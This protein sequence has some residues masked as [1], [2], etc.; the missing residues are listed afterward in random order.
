MEHVDELIAARA[1]RAL[2]PEEER[3]V[4]EHLAGCERCRVELR[5]MEAVASALA[6]SAPPAAPPPELRGRILGSIEPVVPS[7]SAAPGRSRFAWWPRFAAAAM[8]VLAV[9]VLALL[10]WN[11]SLRDRL[12]GRDVSAVARIDGVGSVV[13]YADGDV[14]L[15]AELPPAEE[16]HVYEAWVI[17]G[18]KPLPAG[19]FTDGSGEIDL[20]RPAEEGDVIAVTLEPGAGGDTPRGEVLGQTALEP[21]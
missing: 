1:L 4:D 7:P 13:R 15:F 5:Q 10:A 11:I 6:Y 14:K 16:G 2:D 21:A 3:L 17:R 12:D 18:E 20:S 9:A 19:T 8:P